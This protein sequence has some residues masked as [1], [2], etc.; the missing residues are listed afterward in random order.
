M[1]TSVLTHLWTVS[2]PCAM[3]P[4]LMS[5]VIIVGGGITE[6]EEEGNKHEP[7]PVRSF[8][9]AMPLTKLLNHCFMHIA[10]MSM[11]NRTFE[12]WNWCCFGKK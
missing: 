5:C 6:R 12:T 2:L 9:E 10:M 8:T 11:T 1:S 7:E 3:F 4:A